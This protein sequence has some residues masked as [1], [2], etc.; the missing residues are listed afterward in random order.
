MPGWQEGQE[1]SPF[2]VQSR[3]RTGHD[4]G[5]PVLELSPE[6]ASVWLVSARQTEQLKLCTPSDC[7]LVTSPLSQGPGGTDFSVLL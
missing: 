3:V 5:E 4:T 6:A 7:V 2:L 1:L